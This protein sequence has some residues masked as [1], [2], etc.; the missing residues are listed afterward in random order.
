MHEQSLM[1]DLVRRIELIAQA[2]HAQRVVNV[3][4]RFGALDHTSPDHFREHFVRAVAGTVAQGAELE[5]ELSDDVTD[6]QAQ[7]VVLESVDVEH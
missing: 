3:R 2:E 1:S 4:V 6:P 5:V 7:S